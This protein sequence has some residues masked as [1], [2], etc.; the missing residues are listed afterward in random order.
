[1]RSL[2]IILLIIG[3]TISSVTHAQ[4][5]KSKKKKEYVFGAQVKPIIPI[6]YFGAGPLDLSD[7]LTDLSVNPKLGYSIGMVLRRDFTNL[8]SFETGINYT[9][10]NFNIVSSEA[11]RDTSDL[12]DFGFVSYQIPLQALVYIRLSENFYMN[13]SG[14]L[15]VDWYASSVLST[16]ENGLIQHLSKKAYWMHFS[17]LANVGFEYRTETKGRFYIGASF[18]NPLKPITNTVIRYYYENADYK[19]YNAQLNGTFIT[20]DF[21]YFFENKKEG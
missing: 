10:R 8:L 5:G 18:V 11:K 14:G 3:C 1:M 15:G 19:R 17:L 13:T 16:G 2:S 12:A 7:T 9:R 6:N 21:R 20:V 4:K